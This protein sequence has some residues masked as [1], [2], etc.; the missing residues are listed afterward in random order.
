GLQDAIVA[1]PVRRGPGLAVGR[2]R[3]IDQ[4]RVLLV[5]AGVVEAV[6]VQDARPEVLGHHVGFL[7]QPEDD[8]LAFGLGEVESDALLAT[9]EG[10]EEMTLASRSAGARARALARVVATVG[11]LDLDDLGAHIREDLRAKG[12]GNHAREVDDAN[13]GERW[14]T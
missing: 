1:R 5:Q 8:L 12:T 6:A 4:A 2:D 13:S 3:K 9:I 11:V 7:E 10:H 14:T